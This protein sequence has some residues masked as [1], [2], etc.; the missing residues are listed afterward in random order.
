MSCI[1]HLLCVGMSESYA[2]R[3]AFCPATNVSNASRLKLL[4]FCCGVSPAFCA[5]NTP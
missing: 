1:L 2:G 5:A 4:R 3:F